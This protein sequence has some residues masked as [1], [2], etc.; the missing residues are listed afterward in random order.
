MLLIVLALAHADI[1][2][3]PGYVETCTVANH[4]ASDQAGKTC[5]GTFSGREDCEALEAA[6]WTQKCRTSGA[7]VWTEVM[8]G[9]KGSASPVGPAPAEAPGTPVAPKAT[10]EPRRCATGPFAGAFGLLIALGLVA[11]RR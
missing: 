3:P 5:E 2:P 11:R 7:S 4:C 10:E 6:G 8:C 1:P 9:P